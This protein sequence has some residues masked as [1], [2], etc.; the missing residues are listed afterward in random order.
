[1]NR[2]EAL[3]KYEL[4]IQQYLLEGKEELKKNYHIVEAEFQR[5]IQKAI[6]DLCGLVKSPVKYIQLSLLRT[7]IWQDSYM[8][9]LSIHNE[10]YFLDEGTM[11]TVINIRKIFLPLTELRSKLYAATLPYQGKVDRFDADRII[12]NEAMT[13]YKEK[14]GDFRRYFRD[15]EQW[16]AVRA[17]PKC[18]KLVVKWGEHRDYSETVFLIGFEVEEQ[19]EFL[20]FNQTNSIAEWNTQFV[21]QSIDGAEVH[22]ITMEKKNFLFMGMRK[23]KMTKCVWEFCMLR[24][25]NLKESS[26]SQV[27]FGGSDLSQVDFCAA[28]LEQVRFIQCNLSEADFS[29]VSLS[30]TTFEECNMKGA[31]FSRQNLSYAGLDAHQLQQVLV[32]EEPHVFYNRGR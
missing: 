22:D 27:V 26:I 10:D 20:D 19:K 21:Y 17:M 6:C 13:F 1:M 18:S 3:E 29:D 28:R 32:K 2:E 30:E 15:F 9:L 31:I 24:G 8:L 25:A 11:Q 7:M 4:N 23:G 5:Q 12:M 14:A 16:D